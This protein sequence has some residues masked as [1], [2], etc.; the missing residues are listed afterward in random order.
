M[1]H[2]RNQGH[3]GVGNALNGRQN[4]ILKWRIGR[5]HLHAATRGVCIKGLRTS[6]ML[7]EE[8]TLRIEAIRTN[9]VQVHSHIL[10]E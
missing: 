9:M 2:P 8:I 1:S 10:C 5:G 6:R 3:H 7:V 4:D